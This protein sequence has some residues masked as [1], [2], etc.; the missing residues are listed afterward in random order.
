MTK[1][2]MQIT[3]EPILDLVLLA[4]VFKLI[5]HSWKSDCTALPLYRMALDQELFSP[6]GLQNQGYQIRFRECFVKLVPKPLNTRKH[7]ALN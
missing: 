5:V 4:V 1:T 7:L 6:T 3:V 2:A